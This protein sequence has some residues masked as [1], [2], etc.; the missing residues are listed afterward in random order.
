MKAS[1]PTIQSLFKKS[2]SLMKKFTH[3]RLIAALIAALSAVGSPMAANASMNIENETSVREIA[4][5]EGNVI[6]D[7]NVDVA[8]L[9]GPI[10]KYIDHLHVIHGVGDLPVSAERVAITQ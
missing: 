6:R 1:V 3:T 2:G 8:I 10:P 7:G 9:R 4:F 5:N